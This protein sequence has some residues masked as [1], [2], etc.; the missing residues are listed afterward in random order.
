[1]GDVDEGQGE[2]GQGDVPP[3][4]ARVRS[5]LKPHGEH[6]GHREDQNTHAKAMS[7]RM[8]SRTRAWTSR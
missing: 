7:G 4:S 3:T 6:A 5:R 2:H 8:P 1:M